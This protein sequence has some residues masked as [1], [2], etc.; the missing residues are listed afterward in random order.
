MKDILIDAIAHLSPFK[1]IEFLKVS[2]T[3]EKTTI[4][5]LTEDRSLMVK[6]VT[7]TPVEEFVGVFGISNFER[8][9]A[10]LQNSEFADNGCIK[11]VS[12]E[13]DGEETPTNL[14]F[15]NISGDF[16][17]SFP[18]MNKSFINEKIKTPKLRSTIKWG[19]EFEPSMLAVKRFKAMR[20][21][22]QDDEFFKCSTSNSNGKTSLV[23]SFGQRGSHNGSFVFE[24][25]VDRLEKTHLWPCDNFATLMNLNGNK[26]IKISDMGLMEVE[27]DS[28][29][30]NYT[31]T[32]SAKA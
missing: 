12:Q 11:V 29:L 2:S 22:H 31:F 7:K 20:S 18:F 30:V 25:G 16:E 23:F 14:H 17:A 21:V 28:G 9:R 10:H 24:T 8:L 3:E 27:V 4:R 32:L 26:R 15:R 13:R 19:C 1:G 5:S 6:A